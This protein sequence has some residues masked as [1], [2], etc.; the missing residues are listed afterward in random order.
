MSSELDYE[1]EKCGEPS[2]GFHP[3]PYEERMGNG[4]PEFCN[5]CKQ[6]TKTCDE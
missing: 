6:C 5:C 4:D 3:C 1:C 2:E